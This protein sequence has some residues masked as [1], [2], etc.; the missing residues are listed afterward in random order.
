MRLPN[1]LQAVILD[2][3]GTLHD[4]ESM[5]QIAL[6]RSA[7]NLGFEASNAFC[8]S[9]IGIPGKECDAII[10]AHFGPSFPLV[11]FRQQVTEHC[12]NLFAAGIAIKPGATALV[13]YLARQSIPVAVATSSSRQSAERD[14]SN[15]GLR[16]N[17][18]HVFTRDDVAR[19]KPHPD[20]F[21]MAADALGIAPANCLAVEDSHNGIRAAH[22]AGTMPVMVPDILP[23]TPDIAAICVGVVDDLHAVQSLI[24]THWA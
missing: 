21:L 14:L 11:D 13:D 18:A 16:R 15:S 6:Q 19:G 3:D 8:H 2:M 22:A 4:T 7:R 5:F 12:K 9:L 23:P 17:L 24:S 1:K 20:L 10:H